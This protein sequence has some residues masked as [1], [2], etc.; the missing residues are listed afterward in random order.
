VLFESSE[1]ATKAADRYD[2]VHFGPVNQRIRAYVQNESD[3]PTRATNRYTE[4]I[5]ARDNQIESRTV[6]IT[7]L[8]K[9]HTIHNLNQLLE[10]VREQFAFY[11]PSG[12]PYFDYEPTK[13]LHDRSPEP[14][15]ALVQL[16]KPFMALDI[17]D[18]FAGTYWKNA[19][20]NVRCVPDEKMD[21]LIIQKSDK[22]D[23]KAKLFVTGLKPGMSSTEVHEIFKDYSICD[24]NIP[25]GG[26]TFCFIFLHQADANAVLAQ[27][28]NGYPCQG[29][30]IRVS[31][32]DKGKKKNVGSN[33]GATPASPFLPRTATVDLK[34]NNLPYGVSDSNIRTF[35]QAFTVAK[36]VVKEGYAFVGIAAGDADKAIEVLSGKKVGDRIVT[37]KLAAPR[38]F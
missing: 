26:K 19:T 11:S 31:P 17:I 23:K 6:E 15:V 37:I 20:L 10:P 29:R 3:I 4:F 14:R 33:I 28:G 16:D 1:D 22:G 38:K 9:N 27:F 36:V 32:S 7:G 21:D 30:T 12:D 25:P 24:V 18:R 2:N 13:I 34:V 5:H 35:F 8:P